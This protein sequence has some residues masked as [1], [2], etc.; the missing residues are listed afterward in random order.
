[1]H[2]ELSIDCGLDDKY[3]GYTE[4]NT[5]ITYVSDSS[6]VTTST[7]ARTTR[8]PPLATQRGGGSFH[9]QCSR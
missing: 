6:Y 1:M 3:S 5:G 9:F 4:P 8:S 2:A 7:P